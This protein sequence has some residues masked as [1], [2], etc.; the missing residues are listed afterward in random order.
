MTKKPMLSA[1]HGIFRGLQDHIK[2]ILKRL[3]D[4]THPRL[5]DD[6][7]AAHQKLSEYY[8]WSDASPYYTW[9]ASEFRFF[10][11]SFLKF[12]WTSI[13][14]STWSSYHVWRSWRRF[15]NRCWPSRPPRNVQRTASRFLQYK[16]CPSFPPI[17]QPPGLL[18]FGCLF[19]LPTKNQLYFKVSKE[20]TC[21]HQWTWWIFQASARRFRHMW[22]S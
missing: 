13:L 7:V 9:A 6:L 1:V 12:I 21:C 16:L 5:L 8:F 18:N 22:A 19:G 2:T 4:T 20:R 3:P 11:E 17:C 10:Y 15:R 14:I